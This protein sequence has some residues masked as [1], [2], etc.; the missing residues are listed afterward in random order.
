MA[1][2][3]SHIQTHK[4]L[5]YLLTII[6]LWFY[7]RSCFT[8]LYKVL[9]RHYCLS[10]CVTCRRT[11]TNIWTILDL[12]SHQKIY[13]GV[14]KNVFF[15]KAGEGCFGTDESTFSYILATRNYLQLQATFKAYE[16]VSFFSSFEL[17]VA[18]LVIW[19]FSQFTFLTQK[20]RITL[21]LHFPHSP[22]DFW[23]RD[24]GCN[25]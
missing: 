12:T 24:F 19:V 7:H 1:Y 5:P 8:L 20:H 3:D 16:A 2:K 13:T 14:F 11:L 4:I 23:N 10:T 21:L 9:S 22:P 15:L 25:R 17:N 6:N 18:A